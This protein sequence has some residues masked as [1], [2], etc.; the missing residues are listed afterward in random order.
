MRILPP[1][2]PI[3]IEKTPQINKTRK[4]LKNNTIID[5]DF[6]DY[7]PIP[8]KPRYMLGIEDPMSDDLNKL[9]KK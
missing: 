9:M 5:E 2:V 1:Q 6:E 3:K 7:S 8:P 4:L